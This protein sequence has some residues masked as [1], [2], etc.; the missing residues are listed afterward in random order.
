MIYDVMECSVTIN[1]VVAKNKNQSRYL[2]LMRVVLSFAF[3]IRSNIGC[4]VMYIIAAY[5]SIP[6]CIRYIFL[7]GCSNK[8][9]E[10]MMTVKHA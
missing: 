10:M 6:I 8:K 2:R 3:F 4:R 7:N 1:A 9:S 5:P